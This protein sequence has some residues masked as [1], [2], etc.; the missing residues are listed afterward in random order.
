MIVKHLLNKN[1]VFVL[2][3]FCY[4]ILIFGQLKEGKY[5]LSPAVQ[6]SSEVHFKYAYSAASSIYIG[7]PFTF[8]ATN[9]GVKGVR[10]TFDLVALTVCNKEV[11]QNFDIALD[12]KESKG[13]GNAFFDN[14]YIASV[15]KVD[16]EE[17]I[18]I[19]YL[20]K[21]KML[22]GKNRIKDVYVKNLIINPLPE[23]KLAVSANGTPNDLS[24]DS[25]TKTKKE[26]ADEE[27]L[28]Q[29]MMKKLEK[30]FDEDK[31]QRKVKRILS[32]L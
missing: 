19:E 29:S 5:Y 31:N 14:E 24:N 18:P 4:P 22:K 9:V 16:C 25:G 27:R 15:N 32:Q 20:Y 13:F 12:I 8:K 3:F 6:P 2:L 17:G 26:L 10:L 30:D 21:G 1:L 23:K 7:Q 28:N 11:K